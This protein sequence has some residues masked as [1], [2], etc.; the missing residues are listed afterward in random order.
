MINVSLVKATHQLNETTLTRSN[1]LTAH[2]ASTKLNK[3]ARHDA[4][5]GGNKN[6]VNRVD[7]LLVHVPFKSRANRRRKEVERER[8]RERGHSV[9]KPPARKSAR[10]SRI[11]WTRA[12]SSPRMRFHGCHYDE[13]SRDLF[14]GLVQDESWTLGETGQV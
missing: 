8:E 1:L 3:I 6:A 13:I 5:D 4:S 12:I 11:A 2:G 9:T 10:R 7:S 14:G